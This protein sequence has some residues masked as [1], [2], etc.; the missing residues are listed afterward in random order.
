[1]LPN[2]KKFTLVVADLD[3]TLTK[4]K[5][6]MDSEMSG[7][8]SELLDYKAFAVISG[9]AYPQFHKQFIG[10]LNIS[11]E[12]AKRLYLLPTCATSMYVMKDGQWVS[13]YTES[14]PTETKKEIFKAFDT[15]LDESG[16]KKPEKLYGELIEDR[17]T[18]ITFSAFGQLAPLEVKVTWDPDSKK[19]IEIMKHLLKYLPIG[20]QAKAGGSTSIDVTREG[21][22]KGY[23]IMK[24]EEKLGYKKEEM[25]FIGDKIYEGGNDYPVKATGVYCIQVADPE[26]T[27]S[28]IRQIIKDS[29]QFS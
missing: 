19:R 23:G 14:I 3:E 18:Q 7:L 11:E 22:D 28:I 4:S 9:G 10:S 6:L 1:M 26:E 27:K 21:I 2:F 29:E 12:K 15:A 24:I 25:L 13:V 8:I 5:S 20:Y 17:G 16:F